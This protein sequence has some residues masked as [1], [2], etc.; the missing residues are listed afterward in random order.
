MPGEAVHPTVPYGQTGAGGQWGLDAGVN[1]SVAGRPGQGQATGFPFSGQQP[2]GWNTGGGAA[3]GWQVPAGQQAYDASGRPL[4]AQGQPHPTV[5]YGE[6]PSGQW[7]GPNGW[8]PGAQP[9]Q[10]WGQQPGQGQPQGMP[11]GQQPGQ[12]GG[13]Q[14]RDD[15]LLDGP[16]VPPELRGRT[17]GQVKA[18]YT[19]LA[20][21]WLTRQRAGQPPVGQSQPQGQGQPQQ[22]QQQGMQQPGQGRGGPQWDWSNPGEAFRSVVREEL[23][24]MLQP[25]LAQTSA[26]G[27]VQ[28]RTVAMQQIPDFA[29]L[30]G[31][32]M[33][34]VANLPPESLANPQVWVNAARLAR[35]ELMETGQ[36][37]FSG[38]Q[39]GQPGQPQGQQGQTAT[40]WQGNGGA[41]PGFGQPRA[42]LGQYVNGQGNPLGSTP[43]GM[44]Y[45]SPGLTSVPAQQP[46]QF[47][48]ESPTPPMFSELGAGG[49]SPAE[50]FVAREMGISP[51]QYIVWR[52]GVQR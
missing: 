10:G 27:V 39:Q 31:T 44:G 48:S 11:Q 41:P 52:G 4:V 28:A 20:N 34:H 7:A 43:Q 15:M 29:Y 23:G 1:Y 18:I 9:Q 49:L 47:F 45:G 35:G 37:R 6:Q 40:N 16:N 21:D 3:P 5:P 30:E 25:V 8:Q 50:M 12:P 24:T 38:Q 19:A 36:Y 26:T 42:S 22:G 33:Q 46:Y 13:F 17:F 32:I 51:E 14:L 2:Q